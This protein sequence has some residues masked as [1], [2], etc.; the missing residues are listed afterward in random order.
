LEQYS[1]KPAIFGSVLGSTIV[2]E[3]ILPRVPVRE[4]AVVLGSFARLIPDGS[5]INRGVAREERD[6]RDV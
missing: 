2:P 5:S 3:L 6:S 1:T 4:D